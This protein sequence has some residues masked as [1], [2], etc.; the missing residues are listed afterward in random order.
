M[1][2][3]ARKLLEKHYS[4]WLTLKNDD[5]LRMLDYQVKEDV[6][7]AGKLIFGEA[8]HQSLWCGACVVQ[9]FKQVYT[10]YDQ[11]HTSDSNDRG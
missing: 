1:N 11:L 8:Y 2:E 4:H 6:L 10:R 9:M 7:K 3:E 5:Y